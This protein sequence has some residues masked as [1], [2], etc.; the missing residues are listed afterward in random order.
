M[1]ESGE[2]MKSY[3]KPELMSVDLRSEEGIARVGSPSK[4]HFVDG[5][6]HYN[7]KFITWWEG[8]QAK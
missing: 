6:C 2:K 1:N 4:C 3:V 8:N 5:A 7:G